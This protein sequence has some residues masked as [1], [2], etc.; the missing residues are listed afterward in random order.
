MI[1]VF[2]FNFTRPGREGTFLTL[3]STPT[4]LT[5]AVTGI[6]GGYLL[7][8]YYPPEEDDTH[9]K[10]PWVIWTIL[11]VC[12]GTSTIILIIFRDYFNCVDKE[13]KENKTNMM[14]EDKKMDSE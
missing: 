11:I 6:L 9:K 5:M 8:Y 12:S 7:D 10:R 14:E 4:Y 1:N 13:E 2:T 3:T